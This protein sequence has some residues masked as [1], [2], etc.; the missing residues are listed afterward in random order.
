MKDTFKTIWNEHIIPMGIVIVSGIMIVG[1]IFAF[2]HTPKPWLVSFCWLLF[3]IL[4]TSWISGGRC[5]KQKNIS[6]ILPALTCIT[7][8]MFLVLVWIYWQ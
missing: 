5:T 2:E 4:G 1:V 3:C 8:A 7:L 6:W